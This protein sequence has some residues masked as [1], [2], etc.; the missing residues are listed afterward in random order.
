[1]FGK[2]PIRTV[3]KGDGSTLQL[4]SIFPTL[5]GEGPHAG[6]PAIFIRLGGCNLACDFCDTE[7]EQFA[8]MALED[9]VARID[10][11]S[12]N[13]TG[14]RIRHLVVIT[15]GEPLRQNI[16]PLCESLLVAGFTVQIETNGTVWRPLPEAV[17]VICSPKNPTGGG[18]GMLR[19]DI[20]KRATALKF[21]VSEQ[22]TNYRTVPDVGQSATHTAVYVQPMDEYDAQQNKRNVAYATE[23]A[24]HHGYRLSLQLHKLVGIK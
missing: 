20:L 7:F 1:M 19:P 4:V 10:A 22:H 8:P 13:E 11:E 2:N 18:Y 9:I 21:I 14:A 24:M 17:Q 3:E 16:A 5:Q 6:S 15:G 23:L 12:R